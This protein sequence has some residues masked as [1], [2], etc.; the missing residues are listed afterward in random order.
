MHFLFPGM[1][2]GGLA[3]SA[4]ILIHLFNRFRYKQV[5]WG[6]MELLRKAVIV[7][8]RKIRIEDLLLLTLRC[9]AILLLALALARPILTPEGAPWLGKNKD[10]SVVIALDVSFSMAHKSGVK[11]RFERAADRVRDI[12]KTL[13]PGNPVTLMLCGDRPRFLLHNEPYNADT[14]ETKLSNIVPLPERLNV[15]VCLDEIAS[16]KFLD[17]I[18]LKAPIVEF[19]LVSDAQANSWS[20]LSAKARESIQQLAGAGRVFFLPVAAE[21]AENLAI[22]DLSLKTSLNVKGVTVDVKVANFGSR[23]RSAR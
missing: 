23:E 3:I 11:A 18:K 1:L 21:H 16:G 17:E 2:I 15:D 8:K 12:A 6:A 14:F 10:V 4:P 13:K 22:V 7:R 5:E 9:L 20:A 19:Y